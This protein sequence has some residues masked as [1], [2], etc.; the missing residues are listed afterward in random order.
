MLRSECFTCRR[1]E[2]WATLGNQ[3]ERG[4]QKAFHS[5]INND[6]PEWRG[7][8]TA[9]S[10]SFIHARM[11]RTAGGWWWWRTASEN[12]VPKQMIPCY[13]WTWRKL[14]NRRTCWSTTFLAWMNRWELALAAIPHI[15]TCVCRTLSRRPI[16]R[17]SASENNKLQSTG[18]H[19]ESWICDFSTWFGNIY[20]VY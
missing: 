15:Y 17:S 16:S 2:F 8:Q 4:N 14:D 5:F 18:H 3:T 6:K 10:Q 9:S 11:G 7:R 1:E 12:T 13:A 20:F 19:T